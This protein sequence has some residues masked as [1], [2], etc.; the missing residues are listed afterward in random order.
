MLYNIII[1]TIALVLVK[2]NKI[3]PTA[4]SEWMKDAGEYLERVW[5]WCKERRHDFPAHA[6][7]LRLVVLVQ[8]SSCSVERVF[9]KLDLIRDTCGEKLLDDMCEVRLF[10]QCNG[11]LSKMAA[12]TH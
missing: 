8:L 3:A 6:L 7:A 9:S 10:L 4:P 11:D 12:D 2:R 5:Q 1:K